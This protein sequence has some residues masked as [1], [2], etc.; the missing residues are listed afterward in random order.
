MGKVNMKYILGITTLAAG[1]VMASTG[2]ASLEEA[3]RGYQTK[4]YNHTMSYAQFFE[5]AS[6]EPAKLNEPETLEPG[7]QPKSAATEPISPVSNIELTLL[8]NVAAMTLGLLTVHEGKNGGLVA[9]GT[10]SP[11]ALGD[12]L[13]WVY[14]VADVDGDHDISWEEATLLHEEALRY[15][16]KHPKKKR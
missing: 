6:Q 4:D 2:C 1:A 13:E 12:R 10:Y 7:S 9:I 15:Y 5:Q 16:N 3:L 8:R 11:A 14:H